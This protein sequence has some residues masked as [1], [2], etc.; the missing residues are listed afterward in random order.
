VAEG[1]QVEAVVQQEAEAEG[2]VVEEAGPDQ[3]VQETC[4]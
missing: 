1:V 4:D 2:E 3:Q